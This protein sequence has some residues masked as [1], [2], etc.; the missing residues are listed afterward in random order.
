MLKTTTAK[1][2]PKRKQCNNDK[3]K[4]ETTQIQE[5]PITQIS[6]TAIQLPE[7]IALNEH[8]LDCYEPASQQQLQECA[9]YLNKAQTLQ[10]ALETD[11]VACD[12]KWTLFVAAALSYRYDS[13]LKPFPPQF[14]AEQTGCKID[15]LMSVINDTPKLRVILQNLMEQNYTEINREVTDLLYWVLIEMREPALR[16]VE[17]EELY[18]LLTSIDEKA[19]KFKPTHVFEV[20]ALTGFHSEVAFR[21][22]TLNLPLKLAFMGN[23]FDNYFNILQNGFTQYPENNKNYLELTTDLKKSLQHSPNCAAWGASQCGSIIACTAI[24]EFALDAEMDSIIPDK[25]SKSCVNIQLRNLENIRVR[26]LIFYGKRFPR[27]HLPKRRFLSWIFHHKYSLS[28]ISYMLFLL[29]IGFA[30]SDSGES[31]KLYVCQKID[32]ILDFCRRAI[33]RDPIQSA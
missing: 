28:L 15:I 18:S 11:L 3:P 5:E 31:F 10:Y 22:R 1:L 29:S 17:G 16:L 7:P 14:S 32:S 26:Y 6:A 13:V 2:S 20:Q 23:K 30:N 9:E 19:L 8:S 24:C 27:R 25:Q 21:N 4:Q 33:T 12:A